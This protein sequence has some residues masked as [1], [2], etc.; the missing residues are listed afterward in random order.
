[1]RKPDAEPFWH[2]L[3]AVKRG[4]GDYITPALS[5]PSV[6]TLKLLSKQELIYSKCWAIRRSV[7]D[8]DSLCWCAD[9][10]SNCP[11]LWGI[12]W[13]SGNKTDRVGLEQRL[14]SGGLTELTWSHQNREN[15]MIST[16]GLIF[17]IKKLLKSFNNEF[18]INLGVS[19]LFYKQIDFLLSAVTQRSSF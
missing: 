13:F 10:G 4:E 6:A 11:A 9:L 3:T 17:D 1:M 7:S 8:P 16:L 2:D 14:R 5:S 19:F 18:F 15:S 12:A